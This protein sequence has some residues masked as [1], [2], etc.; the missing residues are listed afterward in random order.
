MELYPQNSHVLKAGCLAGGATLG[1]LET[2]G[3]GA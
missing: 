3:D 1:N 2:L